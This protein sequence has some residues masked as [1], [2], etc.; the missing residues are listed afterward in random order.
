MRVV[1]DANVLIAAYATRGLCEAILEFCLANDDIFL[2]T[3]IL[4][5]VKK[6]LIR[7]IKLPSETATRIVTFLKSNAELISPDE[8]PPG[9]CRDPDDND[10]LGAA[11]AAQA[12]FI[13]TGDDDL[14]VLGEFAGTKIVRP[15]Q[16]W[17]VFSGRK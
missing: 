7:R 17:E 13:I 5:D 6:K 10:I 11:K 3:A 12:D 2:T 4:A 1:L 16:Y 14:L 8:V 15:R 9:L